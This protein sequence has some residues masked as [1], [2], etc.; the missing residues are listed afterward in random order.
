MHVK[1]RFTYKQQNKYTCTFTGTHTDA[2]CCQNNEYRH[3]TLPLSLPLSHSTFSVI[4]SRAVQFYLHQ[5][6]ISGT[7]AQTQPIGEDRPRYCLY[8][9]VEYCRCVSPCSQHVFI[10]AQKGLGLCQAASHN[11]KTHSRTQTLKHTVHK[12]TQV[13]SAI[14]LH[15]HKHIITHFLQHTIGKP[16]WSHFNHLS[17]AGTEMSTFLAHINLHV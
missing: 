16:N 3:H 15:N 12:H 14:S 9:V 13:E 2:V 11:N 6:L 5:P 7:A 4:T 10:K 1:L 8:P 17:Y